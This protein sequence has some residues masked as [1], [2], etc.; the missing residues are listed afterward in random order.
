VF[1]T[2]RGLMSGH[3]E[4]DLKTKD[5]VICVLSMRVFICVQHSYLRSVAVR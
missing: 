2:L 4:R 3:V 1:F 5:V